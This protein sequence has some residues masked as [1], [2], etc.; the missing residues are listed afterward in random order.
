MLSYLCLQNF[1]IASPSE[2]TAPMECYFSTPHVPLSICIV[3]MLQDFRIFMVLLTVE[4]PN[5][6]IGKSYQCHFTR[7]MC[8]VCISS[9]YYSVGL[10]CICNWFA[11]SRCWLFSFPWLPVPE[12][13]LAFSVVTD[14]CTNPPWSVWKTH[15]NM[16]HANMSWLFSSIHFLLL[17][18]L[19]VAGGL[20]PSSASSGEGGVT[21][22]KLPAHHR[23]DI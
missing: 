4:A 23:A 1:Q 22:D 18:L 11:V 10:I 12:Q 3:V 7:L 15:N 16:S 20:E 6:N 5:Y 13:K 17:L 9:W 19:G 14:W 8:N 2:A 21:L